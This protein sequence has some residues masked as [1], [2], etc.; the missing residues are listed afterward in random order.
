M[1][2]TTRFTNAKAQGGPAGTKPSEGEQRQA[3]DGKRPREDGGEDSEEEEDE[4]VPKRAR[5]DKG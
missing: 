5:I 2:A 3:G 4:R 1:P